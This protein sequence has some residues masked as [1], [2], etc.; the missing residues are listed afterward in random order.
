MLPHH[1]LFIVLSVSRPPHGHGRWNLTEMGCAS[2]PTRPSPPP[3]PA[4]GRERP[5]RS[6]RSCTTTGAS[7][8]LGLFPPSL[9]LFY[10]AAVPITVCLLVPSPEYEEIWTFFFSECKLRGESFPPGLNSK[11]TSFVWRVTCTQER[12]LLLQR[13]LL[14][15]GYKTKWPNVQVIT[16]IC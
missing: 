11:R 16:Y 1:H 13:M 8:S 3:L 7:L 15:W 9:V 14:V 5:S 10:T 12:S 4:A 2:L 6:L